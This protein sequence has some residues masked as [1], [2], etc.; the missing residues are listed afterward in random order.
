MF[1]TFAQRLKNTNMIKLKTKR[2]IIVAIFLCL[3]FHKG[4]S[5]QSIV[6]QK[7]WQHTVI[8][9]EYAERIDTVQSLK[10]ADFAS[11]NDLLYLCRTL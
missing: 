3:F 11:F 8:S 1:N 5:S 10:L 7:E 4:E 6:A 2:V 9:T